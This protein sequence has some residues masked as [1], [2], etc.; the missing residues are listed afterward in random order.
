MPLFRRLTI[1][2]FAVA[3]AEDDAD[4]GTDALH[5]GAE[6]ASVHLGHVHIGNDEI[7]LLGIIGEKAQR[8]D[9]VGCGGHLVSQ[10]PEHL[11]GQIDLHGFIVDEKNALGACFRFLGLHGLQGGFVGQGRQ[12]H[13]EYRSDA[14][15]APDV[16]RPSARADNPVDNGEPHAGPPALLFGGVERFKDAFHNLRRHAAARIPDAQFDVVPGLHFGDG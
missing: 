13:I 4:I 8:L 6:Q 12:Q 7:E 14:G 11:L 15:L 3:G 9:A 5:L 10:S 2:A 1:H 16:H